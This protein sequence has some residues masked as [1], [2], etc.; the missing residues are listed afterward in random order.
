M[1]NQ[2]G[3]TEQKVQLGFCVPIEDDDHLQEVAH[4]S[5]D[6]RVWDGGQVGGQPVWLDPEHLPTKVTCRQC[7]ND[8]KKSLRFIC[9]LY[10]PV[11]DMDRA[12]HRTLYVF[13]CP[14]C[15]SVRVLRAQLPAENSY[16]PNHEKDT[17]VVEEEVNWQRHLPSEYNQDLCAVCGLKGTGKCPLQEKY[18]CGPEHQ[19]EHKM[20]RHGKP[21]TSLLKMNEG[22]IL[23]SVYHMTQLVVEEEPEPTDSSKIAPDAEQLFDDNDNDSDDDANLE[24][25]DLNAMTGASTSTASED[26]VTMQFYQRIQ[27]RPNARDQCLRYCRWADEDD[28]TDVPLWIRQENQCPNIP[29]CI[30]C[31]A[32]RQFEFQLMPQLLHYL[33]QNRSKDGHSLDHFNQ[34]KEALEQT[35]SLVQQAPP[36]QIP[37][38]LMEARDAAI[39][40]VQN[41]LLERKGTEVEWGVVAVYTCTESC[42]FGKDEETKDGVD[43]NLG[44]YR[45]EFA[46]V[47]SS[48]DA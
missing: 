21:E 29:P 32:K 15:C 26:P 10:A 16:Y 14:S 48:L 34:L 6:Y 17:G 27:E 42:N 22:D 20:H 13:A 47:Q 41:D 11:D 28:D 7:P 45:E 25:T 24:Q 1:T 23:P 39:Q 38:T 3:A 44:A 18:F 8:N 4:R 43:P 9:Q 40:R 33:L 12:F 5:A 31:G 36:E 46:W 2:K 35:D 37:P 30:Y 19:R